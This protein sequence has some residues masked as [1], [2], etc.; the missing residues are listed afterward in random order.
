M[1]RHYVTVALRGFVK[2]RLHSAVSVAV[3]ALGLTCFIA[4]YLFVSYLRSYDRHFV[5]AERIHVIFQ[6]M[7][8]PSM[9]FSWPSYPASSYLLGEQLALDVPELD[10]VA[11]YR[12]ANGAFVTI[13]GDSKTRRIGYAEPAF[14][15]IFDFQTLTGDLDGALAQPQSAVITAS[16]AESLF[17]THDVVG[18][19]FTLTERQSADVTVVAVI[20]DPPRNSHLGTGLGASG[21]ELLLSWN[22]G[23]TLS[24]AMPFQKTWFNTTTFTYVLLPADGSVRA[25]DLDRRLAALVE[26]HVPDQG[27]AV[28]LRTQHVSA[29]TAGL[30]QSQFQ[31]FQGE[32]RRFD[33]FA[34]LLVFAGVILAVACVNFVNLATARAAARAREIG[35]RKSVGAGSAQIVVQELLQTGVLAGL[36]ALLGVAAVLALA[37]LVENPW[38]LGLGIPWAEPKFW[39]FLAGTVVAVTVIAGLYP[40]LVLARVRPVAALRVGTMRAGPKFLRTLLVGSQFAVASLLIATVVVVFA[41]R[42]NLREALLGRFTDQY[43]IVFPPPPGATPLDPAVVAAELMNSPGIKGVTNGPYPWQFAGS[44]A[45][46]ARTPDP[47][48]PGVMVETMNVGYDYFT[49]MEIPL[50]AGRAF[51]RDRADVLPLTAAERQAR[52]EPLTIILDSDAARAL[53]WTNPA[54]AIGQHVHG[55]GRPQAVSFEVVGVAESVPLAIRDRGSLGVVY[56]LVP[57][58]ATP[59]I[60]RIAKDSVTESLAH[61]DSVFKMVEPDRPPRG[62]VFVDLVFE[63]AYWTFR[64]ATFVFVT[65]GVVAVAIAAFGLFGMASYMTARRTREIGLRKT[66]GASSAQ[67]LRLLTWQFSRPV[68]AANVIAWPIAL[69]AADRYLDLFAERAPITPIPF[70]VA[71]LGTLLVAWLAV[72]GRV[73]RA[74]WT[75]P[76]V[77]LRDE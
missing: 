4:A 75:S 34:A 44:R 30:L 19:T 40:A 20:A 53:G 47:N 63:S 31:G 60:V 43:V 52:T 41:Q 7:E 54:E 32:R 15:D 68:V 66:Q 70:A 3:L 2:Y 49:V 65:L 64:L 1:L 38:R 17:G 24:P 22:M 37:P 28:E 27:I 9:G 35:V 36:A 23:E 57:T 45:Q 33:V 6:G 50:A 12:T 25:A 18:R 71:L 42:D 46:Y 5:N 72:G 26:R 11:R 51:A 67:V 77:A 29:F 76:A 16:A 62:R 56:F 48:A 59:H 58:G 69:L 14:L 8:G 39:L 61:V 73:V 13:D 55:V 21:F 10:A 74:A